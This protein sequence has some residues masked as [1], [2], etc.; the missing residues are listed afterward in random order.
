MG[1]WIQAAHPTI[2]E[3]FA[4]TGFD[5]VAV[6]CEHTDV[7]IKDFAAVA[8][9]M[10]GR[11]TPCLARVRENNTLAIRQVLDLGAD[12]VIVPLVNTAEEAERAVQAAKFP[13]RGIRGYSYVRANDWGVGFDE[14]AAGANEHVA[15]A[16][17]I[18]SKRGVENVESILAVDDLDS[19]F[20]GPYDMSGSYGVP[21]RTDDPQV[22]E[23]CRRVRD[24]A[25]AAGKPAGI[26]VVI[27]TPEAID[28]ALSDGFRFLGLGLDTVFL[29]RASRE[30][31]AAARGFT[32]K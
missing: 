2:A 11:G 18:E 21:G 10:H 16:V 4:E 20:I 5:Y 14:Y 26:H 27:P 7:D 3:I 17:M 29:A 19:V 24:A 25:A 15:V 13:P 31:L 1:T 12:G 23:G 28:K 22:L 32:K 30:A 8:R 6:D 9:A